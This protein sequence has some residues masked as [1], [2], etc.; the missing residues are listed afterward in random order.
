MAKSA[1]LPF[2]GT[3]E[4]SQGFGARPSVYAKFGLQG[5]DGDDWKMPEGTVLFSP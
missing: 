3:F 2:K 5:H 4:H 1:S